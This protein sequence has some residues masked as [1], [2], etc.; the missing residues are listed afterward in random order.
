M[1][2]LQKLLQTAAAPKHAILF[3]DAMAALVSLTKVCFS[4]KISECGY[5]SALH[6]YK[7]A[8]SALPVKKVP[9]KMHIICAHL[10]CAIKETGRGLGADSEQALEAA[11]YD[12]NLVWKRYE[13]RDVT[14]EIYAERLLR[15]VITYNVS[16]IPV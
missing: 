5:A 15:A 9:V 1:K 7:R 11:H 12:F 2:F 6:S 4:K 13:V 10:D 8:C 16:H 3:F 14:S